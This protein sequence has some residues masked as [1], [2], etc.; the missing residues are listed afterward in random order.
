MSADD[1]ARRGFLLLHGWQNHRPEGHWQRWLSCRL[2]ALGHHVSYPQLPDPDEPD[3]TRWL[4]TLHR[5]LAD[6]PDGERVVVCHSLACLLWLHAIARYGGE[7]RVDRVLL[8]APP[9][10]AV[11]EYHR[12]IATFAAPPVS[13]AQVTA[14]ASRGSLIVAG[15][16]DPYC[17]EGAAAAYGRPLGITTRIVS[18]GGHLDMVA[19]YGPWPSMLSWCLNPSSPFSQGRCATDAGSPTA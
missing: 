15:D 4:D 17:S 1:A 8:A 16:D 10:P 19:G 13:A 6:L 7:I 11:V 18:G 9:S 12:E 2:T 3:R 5:E 14:A